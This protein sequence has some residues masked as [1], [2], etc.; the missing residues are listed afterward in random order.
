MS[1]CK[2]GVL[3]AEGIIGSF[4]GRLDKGSWKERMRVSVGGERAR[5]AQLASLT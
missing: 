2:V 4:A 1:W 3:L 5:G